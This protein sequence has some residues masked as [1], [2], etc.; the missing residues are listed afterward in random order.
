VALAAIARKSKLTGM[1]GARQMRVRDRTGTLALP[2]GWLHAGRAKRH[3][4]RAKRQNSRAQAIC[5]RGFMV[6]MVTRKFSVQ[7]LNN[8]QKRLKK[9]EFWMVR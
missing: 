2:K 1:Y 4:T 9:V 8:W 7:D 6:R 3:S 5:G